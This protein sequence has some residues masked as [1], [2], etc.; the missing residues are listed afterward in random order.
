M[1]DLTALRRSRLAAQAAFFVQGLVFISLTTRLPSVRDQWDLSE[2][3]LSLVL[4][5]MVLLAG[6]GSLSAE[7]LAKRR[8]SATVL[9]IGLGIITVA[10]PTLAAAPT[11]GVFIAGMALYG[12]G[13]GV[14]DAGTN[15]QAV[16]VEHLFGRPILPSFHG[17]WTLGGAVGA[18]IAIATAHLDL[19]Q[20][21]AWLA[22]FPLVV[23]FAPF[24]RRDT[25]ELTSAVPAVPRKELLML[26][27]AM[28]LFYSVDTAASTW[29]P[30]FLDDTFGTPAQLV[31]LAI[32]PYLLASLAMRFA[33]DGLV[34]RFGP[35]P[36]LRVGA[37]A[38]SV[39]LLIVVVSP[40]WQVAV[41][42]FTL[43]GA[44]VA[45]IAP[46]SFS[47]AAMLAG[48]ADLDPAAQR[49]RTD[50]LIGRFNQFN[51]LGA[52][53]GAVMT[54]LVGNGN[55]RIGFAVPMV[56]ILLIWPL[57]PAFAVPGR[58]VDAA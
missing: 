42:G 56:L 43:L 22:I 57:A 33:G 28:V 58:K 11:F 52:L 2:N 16:A 49:A 1:P 51:Y 46:L 8:D 44:S 5:M 30:T 4:L 27:A 12:I 40:T 47:A 55:L 26:G 15:M 48:G 10:V 13:L 31:P 23:V 37:L 38:A 32:F 53:I 9:R 3:E 35:K 7:W 25:G 45:V 14:V 24:V 29:G 50:A 36:V 34:H 39:A 17:A 21:A 19:A 41:L 20:G 18:A 54:G 6:V